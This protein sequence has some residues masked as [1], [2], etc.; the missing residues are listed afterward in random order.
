MTSD[1]GALAD[2]DIIIGSDCKSVQLRADKDGKGDGRVYP[3]T[4]SVR[5]AVGITS[6]LARK[7][8]VPHDQSGKKDTVDSGA[9]YTVTSSCP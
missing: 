2:G 8:T 5:D 9:R 3:I 1:E 4:F 6:T 7:V